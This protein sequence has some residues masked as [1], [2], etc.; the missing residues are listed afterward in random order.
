MP[1]TISGT[2]QSSREGLTWAKALRFICLPFQPQHLRPYMAVK[3]FEDVPIDHLVNDGIEGILLDADGTLCPHHARQFT[4]NVVAHVRKMQDMGLRV[5]IF[6]NSSSDRFQQFQNT[7]VV[8]EAYAKPDPRGFATAM[9]RHLHL[10]D[11]AKICMIG[12][13]FITDGG[14]VAAGMRFIYVQ[15]IQGTEGIVHSL[16]RYW[17]FLWAKFYFK[18]IFK[19]L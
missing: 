7:E 2:N 5:A 15:P 1:Q 18:E 13:S 14:A 4:E 6:T 10:N 11:P 3:R 17:G 9:T 8:G 16:T 19:D 12:D